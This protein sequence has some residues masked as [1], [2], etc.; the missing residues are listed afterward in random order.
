MVN[1]RRGWVRLEVTSCLIFLAAGSQY[2]PLP[3]FGIAVGGERIGT[4]WFVARFWHAEPF[5][6]MPIL[7]GHN[8]VCWTDE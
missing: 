8:S 1:E 2:Y 6:V 4:D 5:L 3:R 7:G